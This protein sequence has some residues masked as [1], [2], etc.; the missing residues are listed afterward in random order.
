[1]TYGVA[2]VG[3]GYMARKHCDA[4]LGQPGVSLTTICSTERSRSVGEELRT[5]YG[6]DRSTP[7]YSTVLTDANT[8]IVLICT[9]DNSH[10]EQV[11]RALHAGK[12]VLCEKPLAR[13]AADFERLRKELERSGTILQVG[14]NCRFRDQYSK[15]R[16]LADS[17]ELGTPRFLRGTYVVNVI[18]PVRGREK[19]WWLDYAPNI[20]PLLHGGGI[21][22]LDLLRWIGGEVDSVFARADGFELGAE[23]G[24]D[25]F[26]VSMRF[27]SGAMG[28]L[29]VSGSAPRPNDFSLELW[30]SRASILGTTVFRRDGDQESLAVEEILVEQEVSDLSLQFRDMVQAIENRRE[31]RNSFSEAYSNFM[32]VDAVHRSIASGQAV[33][34][35]SVSEGEGG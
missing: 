32:V 27:V 1:M 9:P 25:T 30:F 24:S 20:F 3:T 18:G 23:L 13:D 28:E 8:D 5:L 16:E 34:V 6:F 35:G 11:C 2:V 10:A 12:H 31:P 15:A 22:A 17:G 19:P 29:L 21:H 4:L 33:R 7:D 14:M 26:S